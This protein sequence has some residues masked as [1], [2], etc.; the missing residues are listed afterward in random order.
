MLRGEDE[1]WMWRRMRMR[2]WD[3]VTV[4]GLRL[5]ALKVHRLIEMVL[6]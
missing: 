4:L 2:E 6:N 3:D 1:G 5:V